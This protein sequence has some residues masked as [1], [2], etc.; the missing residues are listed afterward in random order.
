M[1]HLFKRCYILSFDF[2][3]F[4]AFISL[5]L[6]AFG[7]KKEVEKLVDKT[8]ILG[9]PAISITPPTV[10]SLTTFDVKVDINPGEKQNLVSAKLVFEDL[11][12]LLAPGFEKTIDLK[13]TGGPSQ[14]ISVTSPA[15]NHDYSVQAI[16]E[17]DKYK[18]YSDKLIIRFPKNNFSFEVSQFGLFGFPNMLDSQVGG[19]MSPGNS[20]GLI[21]YYNT[22]PIFKTIEAKLNGTT[23]VPFTLTFQQS[24]PYNDQLKTVGN[25][26]IP[27][28]T[29]PGDYTVEVNIDGF[30]YTSTN[31]IRILS[32]KWSDYDKLYPGEKLVS[33]SHFLLGD[34]LYL[35]GGS[36][37]YRQVTHSPVW[38]YNLVSKTWTAKK[39][40]PHTASPGNFDVY[41]YNLLFNG[42]GYVVVR[43][44]EAMELWRYSQANDQW[45]KITTYPGV[46][47]VRTSCFIINSKLY[48]SSAKDDMDVVGEFWCYDLLMG[49]WSKLNSITVEN[50]MP[51]AVC[52]LNGKAYVRNGDF[53]LMEYNPVTDQWVYKTNFPGYGRQSSTL[54]S[55]NNN[56]YLIG[57]RSSDGIYGSFNDCWQYSPGTDTWSLKATT[58][59]GIDRGIAFGYSG[60]IICG[61][62]DS[63]LSSLDDILYQFIP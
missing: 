58:P 6:F 46:G 30:K 40:F 1:R 55:F 26:T 15:L 2:V 29:P 32:G 16:L 47:R 43:N 42:E 41:N 9:S 20:F 50:N 49:T 22:T 60:K 11:T 23:V 21:C 51:D 34:K 33:F 48:L 8:I 38:E 7:C 14:T 62:S 24:T 45:T 3:L 44:L 5:L 28:E 36:F 54:V 39:D 27:A 52:V 59:L 57:G 37:P 31:K 25:I 56:I 18:Y 61:M 12:V 63:S 19:F 35:V 17:S 10:T 53:R 13:V 4:I